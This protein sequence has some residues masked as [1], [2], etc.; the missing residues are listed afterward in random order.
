MAD[1]YRDG[2]Y[3]A[4][5]PSLHLEDSEYKFGYLCRLLDSLTFSSGPIRVLDIGGGAGV[6]AAQLCKWLASGGREVECHAYDLS[7]DMLRVQC[8]N[9]P[10]LTLAT[11]KFEE[12]RDVGRYDL[13]L[14]ID[15]IEHIPDN[16]RIAADVD[17]IADRLLYNIPIERN[18]VDCLRNLYM[19]GR[20]YPMQEQSLGHVH[21]YSYAAAKRFVAV[22]HRLRRWIVPDYSGYLRSSQHE[23]YVRQ[24][25]N[26]LR[27]M[28]LRLSGLV[29]RYLRPLVPWL[30]QG[31]LFMLAES[32]ARRT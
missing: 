7:S 13:A 4:S 31:S 5:N 27:G 8:A 22:H 18:L 26:R 16:G 17:R 21:F 28:E 14:L 15:V 30:I 23:E 24:R 3:I 19:G 32:R 9:N 10:Y 20:Y 12:L 1:I 6:V 29:Y 11:T 25:A 2:Q